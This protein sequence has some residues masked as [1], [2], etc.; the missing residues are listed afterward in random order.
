MVRKLSSGTSLGISPK[1]TMGDKNHMR[2]VVKKFIRK[3][4]NQQI[5][6][7]VR[8]EHLLSKEDLMNPQQRMEFKKVNNSLIQNF[9]KRLSQCLISRRM[10]IT[11]II[12]T[13]I[14]DK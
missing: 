6:L 14:F 10:C 3:K 5:E 13:R 1:N 7:H 9:F 2:R 11:D 4:I 8:G 12:H